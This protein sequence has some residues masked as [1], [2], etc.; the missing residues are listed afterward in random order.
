MVKF[1]TEKGAIRIAGE[2]VEFGLND[3]IVDRINACGLVHG[4]FN[5]GKDAQ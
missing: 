3:K 1:N 4:V 2:C 5:E